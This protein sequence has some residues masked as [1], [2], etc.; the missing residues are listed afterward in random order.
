MAD[1]KP[2]GRSGWNRKTWNRKTLQGF[3]NHWI[4]Q[5][6][7]FF[8]CRR[9]DLSPAFSGQQLHQWAASCGSNVQNVRFSRSS[10]CILSLRWCFIRTMMVTFKFLGFADLRKSN[11]AIHGG[12]FLGNRFFFWGSWKLLTCPICPRLV[13]LV[14]TPASLFNSTVIAKTIYHQ[15]SER[16]WRAE[17]SRWIKETSQ[18]QNHC[19]LSPY[20]LKWRMATNMSTRRPLISTF[21]T[22]CP[23]PILGIQRH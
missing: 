2:Q 16:I 1:F 20:S 18:T 9:W 21:G 19:S 4:V 23:I 22:G 7:S 3:Y 11:A 10:W 13:T 14:G 8:F 5:R 15:P 12:I 6:Q 17:L